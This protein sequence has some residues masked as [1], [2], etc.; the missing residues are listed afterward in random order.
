MPCPKSK[1]AALRWLLAA[2]SGAIMML[3]G[4]C[5]ALVPTVPVPDDK[6][7]HVAVPGYGQIRYGYDRTESDFVADYQSALRAAPV[8]PEGVAVLALSGGGANGAFSAGLLCDWTDPGRRPK[9]QVVTGVSTGALAAPFAFLGAAYDERLIRAYTTVGDPD[10]FVPRFVRTAFNLLRTD[11]MADTTPLAAYIICNAELAQEYDPIRPALLP[12]S[13]RTVHAL[14]HAEAVGDL[15]R[16]YG[17]TVSEG[18]VFRLAAIPDD[19]PLQHAGVFNAEFMR[20]L[21]D[22]GR[23]QARAGYAWLEQPPHLDISR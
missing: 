21:F 10:V 3:F 4:G 6:V 15:H 13:M 9:F 8:R 7:T 5:V 18:A 12:I 19:F 1:P 20:R 16:I 22:F 14:I 2:G 11:S 17:R 23:G